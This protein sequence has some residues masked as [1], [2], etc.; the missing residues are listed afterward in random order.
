MIYADAAL[1]LV[2]KCGGDRG[3]SC[4]MRYCFGKDPGG[5]SACGLRIVFSRCRNPTLDC[6]KVEVEKFRADQR[7]AHHVLSTRPA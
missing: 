4:R 7:T 1:G 6:F 3:T 5:W 2:G